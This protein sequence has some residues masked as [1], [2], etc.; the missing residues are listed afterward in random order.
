[1]DSPNV[2]GET[3]L[4]RV[5]AEIVLQRQGCVA[6]PGRVILL[7]DRRFK[8]VRLDDARRRWLFR[9]GGRD[10]RRTGAHLERIFISLHA[11]G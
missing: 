1:M 5:A 10:Q 9:T 2:R 3:K 7:G 6:G 8:I 11:R 4:I